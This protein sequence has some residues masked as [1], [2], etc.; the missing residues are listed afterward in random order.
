MLK[1][2][3]T[4]DRGFR[5]LNESSIELIRKIPSQ[6][7]Y[8]QVPTSGPH[9]QCDSFGECLIRSAATA[10]QVFGGITTN[11]WDDPFEWTLPESLPSKSDVENYLAEVDAARARAFSAILDDAELCREIGLPSGGTSS[12]AD[13]LVKAL[14]RAWRQQGI[15]IQVYRTVIDRD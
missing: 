9:D 14:T 13:V 12:L 1:L 8:R 15:A 3:S 10:E 7:L 2:T 4:I 5:E 6:L 11:L